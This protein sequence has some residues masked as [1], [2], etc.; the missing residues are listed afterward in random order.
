MMSRPPMTPRLH[1]T[2]EASSAASSTGSGRGATPARRRRRE[3]RRVSAGTP[4]RRAGPR[5][6][7][8]RHRRSSWTGSTPL[9]T[10]MLPMATGNVLRRHC[11][12]AAPPCVRSWRL[13]ETRAMPLHPPTR[14]GPKSA[15]LRCPINS[16]K[17]AS[18]TAAPQHCARSTW[19]WARPTRTRTGAESFRRA[20]TRLRPYALTASTPSSAPARR[21]GWPNCGTV[22]PPRGR[23]ISATTNR[24]KPCKVL[25]AGPSRRR[26]RRSRRSES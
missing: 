6:C 7:A 5:S 4:W 3:R 22:R 21:P 1:R 12:R 14:A 10:S 18:L 24:S 23:C 26:T 2:E 11:A 17:R 8:S 9:R 15:S 13:T 19:L 20:R 25:R 16:P